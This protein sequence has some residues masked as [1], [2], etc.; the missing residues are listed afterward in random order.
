MAL[1][2][3]DVLCPYCL[4]EIRSKD[5]EMVCE[6]CGVK[7]NPSKADLLLKKSPKCQQSGCRGIASNRRCGHCGG[8]LPPDILDY[9]KNMRFSILGIAGC[10][11]T[12]FLTTMLH[13]LRHTPGCPW[14]LSS[15]D[16]QTA[17]IF[18]ENDRA[19]YEMRQPVAATAAGSSPPPQ[20]WRIKDRNRMTEKIIPS[21]SLTIFDGAGEDCSHIDPV[22][23]RYINGSKVLFIL[24]DPLALPGVAKTISRDILNWSTTASHDADA[25]ADMVDGLANYVR[26]SCNISPGKLIDRDVAVVFTKIDAVKDSFGT[27]TVVQ[28][29]PHLAQKGFVKSDADAVDAEIRDWLERQGESA[30]INAIETNFRASRVRFFGISSFGQPPTGNF[31][32]GRVMPHRVLD[33][34][35]WMLSKEGIVPTV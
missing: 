3:S 20:L 34:L 31:R 30:F 15:M 1:F 35:I 25:S 21:Y 7:A 4:R 11:K 17:A 28:P 10:G 27:A 9:E 12:N 24:I 26:R 33:P 2:R 32:L 19:V 22:I 6:L 5:L 8:K 14:V 18:Q 23:S 16:D 13:E 29:S